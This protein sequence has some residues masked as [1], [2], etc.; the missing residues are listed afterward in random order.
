MVD[1]ISQNRLVGF[2]V[3]L[4]SEDKFV[5][6]PSCNKLVTVLEEPLR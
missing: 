3:V 6:I 5:E 1:W 4:L 2:I